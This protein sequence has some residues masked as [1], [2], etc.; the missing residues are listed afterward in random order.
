MSLAARL[1]I[2]L[3][4]LYQLTLRPVIGAQCRFHPHC[5]A[6]AIEALRRHGA[7]RGTWLAIGRVLRCNP[8]HEG[9]PDPVPEK[10]TNT[11]LRQRGLSAR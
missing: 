1:L 11:H 2:G 7:L 9:G 5:S 6:Y 10:R 8:W 4:R 3:V